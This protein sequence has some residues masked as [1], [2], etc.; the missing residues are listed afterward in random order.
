MSDFPA[1]TEGTHPLFTQRGFVIHTRELAEL[2]NKV[3][4]AM[5]AG[6]HTLA[7]YG[8]P[9]S[10]KTTACLE[11]VGVIADSVP[12]FSAHVLCRK[13]QNDGRV[14]LNNFWN[15]ILIA[16]GRTE[17]GTR[18]SDA[19]YAVYQHIQTQCDLNKNRRLFLIFDESQ[20][21]PQILLSELKNFHDK[22]VEHKLYPFFLFVGQVGLTELHKKLL[23]EGALD[24][25]RRFFIRWHEFKS[26]SLADMGELLKCYDE[27]FH[28][29]KNGPT[30][31]EYFA[32]KSY[33]SGWRLQQ[34]AK[35]LISEFELLAQTHHQRKPDRLEMSV[36]TAAVRQ[37]LVKVGEAER[38]K[39]KIDFD[40][41]RREA[42]QNCGLV[43]QWFSF[44]LPHQ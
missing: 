37:F 1:L 3:V 20:Y 7:V 31:T 35:E 4:D 14:N 18:R 11:L 12:T 43:E 25:V 23:A 6:T 38:M 36:I 9:G 42:V 30:F 27:I 17:L 13:Y 19:E 34:E 2:H 33:A 5:N 10:G 15:D 44:E 39:I 22:L 26:S 29:P 41:M 16:S 28:F 32:P 8:R 21:L 24:L 40:L